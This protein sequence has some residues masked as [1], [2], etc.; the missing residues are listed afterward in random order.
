MR[1]ATAI[2]STVVAPRQ[3]FSRASDVLIVPVP[4]KITDQRAD[5]HPSVCIL[6][7]PGVILPVE[8]TV[9]LCTP[10]ATTA[11]WFDPDSIT[12]VSASAATLLAGSALVT[13][14]P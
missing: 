7:P 3:V 4:E 12:P 2:S 8:S 13:L 14:T 6:S 11:I 10:P 5:D 9:S 1:R